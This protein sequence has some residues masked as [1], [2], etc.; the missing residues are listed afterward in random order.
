[1]YTS[2][3]FH[4]RLATFIVA[5]ALLLLIQPTP[6]V[7]GENDGAVYVLG[8][9]DSGNTVIV[10]R[11]AENGALTRVQE[12]STGGLGS[13]GTPDPLASQGALTL[14]ESGHLLFAVNAGSN[15][16]S[17]LL[18]TEDG[19]RLADRK[20]SGGERP[21]SVTVH[22]NVVYVLNASGTPNISGFFVNPHGK[23][24]PIPDSTR[25]LAGG[26]SAAPAEVRFS[27]DGGLLLVTEKGT[28]LID[29]FAVDDD[30]HIFRQSSQSSNGST[31]FGFSFVRGRSLIVSEAGGSTL[32][33]YKLVEE[34]ADSD[35]LKIIS[36]SVPN[37]QVAA[38]WVVVKSS[39]RVAF[40]SN[41]GSGT[42]SSFRIAPRGELSLIAGVAADLG[43]GSG[44]IDMALSH[45]SRFLYVLSSDLG[46]V[47]GFRVSGGQLVKISQQDGLPLSMQGLAAD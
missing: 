30:G 17:A 44:A 47:T 41:T 27:P 35:D 12:A 40:S 43:A 3:F 45:G 6:A 2:K 5:I 13:G 22:G 18:V 32:S 11:R 4:S 20:P 19:L 38:C 28:S 1:M 39:R 42:I 46:T 29:L 36:G 34:D 24:T 15:D 7:A 9:Q 26:A 8:N 16:L 33:S 14:N 10:F 25:L 31:P 37:N 21:V 23:L